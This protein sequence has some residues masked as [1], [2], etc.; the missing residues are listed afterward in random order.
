MRV[1]QP[2]AAACL[3]AGLFTAG[4]AHM[5]GKGSAQ[6]QPPTVEINVFRAAPRLPATLR[7]VAVL[8]LAVRADDPDAVHGRDALEPVLRVELAQSRA[9]EL[10]Y[11]TTSEARGLGNETAWT[12]SKELPADFLARIQKDLGCDGVIFCELTAY[13]AYAP[14]LIGWKLT[15]VEATAGQVVWAVDQSFDAGRPEVADAARQYFMNNI[16]VTRPLRDAESVL[17]SPRRFGQYTAHAVV[18]TLP[19]R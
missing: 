12:T 9:F 3:M 4:C 11:V 6:A 18:A 17:L 10:V 8:P 16:Q 5:P 19:E 15:L 13:R 7:R 14:M 1:F 2:I